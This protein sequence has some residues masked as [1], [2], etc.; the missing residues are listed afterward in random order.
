MQ[1]AISVK[2]VPYNAEEICGGLG[3]W[4]GAAEAGSCEA[5]VGDVCSD[6]HDKRESVKAIGNTNILILK[7]TFIG[8]LLV[9][10]DGGSGRSD[11]PKIMQFYRVWSGLWKL[12]TPDLILK[13]NPLLS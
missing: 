6:T 5:G 9:I 3:V 13:I 7:K 12:L 4:D 2:V 1:Y 11:H 10:L 8:L